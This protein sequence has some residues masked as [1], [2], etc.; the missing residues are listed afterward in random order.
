MNKK[1]AEALEYISEKKIADA[2]KAR[3][4]SRAWIGAVAAVLALV[5]LIQPL[6]APTT[7]TASGLIAAPEY[8]EM[9]QFPL[10]EDFT[11]LGI[12]NWHGYYAAYEEWHSNQNAQRNQPVGYAASLNGYFTQS[13]PLLLESEGE[14]TVC[15]PLNIYMALAM[16]AETAAGESRTQ[17]LDLLGANSITALRKQAGQVWN[18]HYMD[19]GVT[20]TILANSLWLDDGLHYNTDTVATLAKDYYA[21]VYQGKLGS[22]EVNQMLRNWLNEQTGGLL[23]EQI[24]DVELSPEAVMALASTIY[25]KVKWRSEFYEEYN[26]E[27][28]FHSPEGDTTVTYMNKTL[29]PAPYHWGEHFGA[30]CLDMDDGSKMWLILPDEDSTVEEVLSDGQALEMVLKGSTSWAGKKS[31][32]INLSLPKFDVVSDRK[33][34]DQLMTLGVADVFDKYAADFSAILP[35]DAAYLSTVQHT[36][37]VVIDE[38]GIEAAAYTLMMYEATAM[39]PED[40]DE[41][42]FTL[43]RPFLFV[44]ASHDDLPLFAGVVNAP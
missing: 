16:L 24:Q 11:A 19:D 2:A 22:D 21:S 18:A 9:A 41:I 12:T 23:E 37:R 34:N 30:V 5:L 27:D 10:E 6:M 35:E 36:A 14:N 7:A 8:P 38:E 17:I 25:Y 33:I 40:M 43:D 44:I 39:E 13:I 1:L 4:R 20:S 15:S 31:I 29:N 28:V 32:K 26:T 42:D 3:R